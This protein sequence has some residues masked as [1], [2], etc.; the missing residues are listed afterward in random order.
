MFEAMPKLTSLGL[1]PAFSLDETAVGFSEPIGRFP[2]YFE[3]LDL[4]IT[5]DTVSGEMWELHRELWL[6]RLRQGAD[7][8]FHSFIRHWSLPSFITTDREATITRIF[9]PHRV[10]TMVLK[11]TAQILSLTDLPLF[12]SLASSVTKLILAI[13]VLYSAWRLAEL[14]PKLERMEFGVVPREYIWSRTALP[15][16]FA[17]TRPNGKATPRFRLL[18][19]LEINN[20]VLPYELYEHILQLSPGLESLT[21]TLQSEQQLARSNVDLWQKPEARIPPLTFRLTLITLYSLMRSILTCSC[22]DYF[23]LR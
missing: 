20:G 22:C 18:R 7:L 23:R 21:V 8:S 15:E 6:S 5:F 19:W 16:I 10:A 2:S 11:G 4:S 14:F 3:F 9:S 1:Y 12:C 13:D 17:P